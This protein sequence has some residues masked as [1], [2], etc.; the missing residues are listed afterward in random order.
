M[1]IH[2]SAGRLGG[3]RGYTRSRLAAQSPLAGIAQPAHAETCSRRWVFPP[4]AAPF[5]PDSREKHPAAPPRDDIRFRGCPRLGG[6]A[7]GTSPTPSS[8]SSPSSPWLRSGRHSEA[9]R[10]KGGCKALGVGY[11]TGQHGSDGAAQGRGWLLSLPSSPSRTTLFREIISKVVSVPGPRCV[12][13][14]ALPFTLGAGRAP[15]SPFARHYLSYLMEQHL[16][17][18]LQ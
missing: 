4:S 13:L 3:T 11:G 16:L 1:V 7:R 9:T 15:P 18:D 10:D 2:P 6:G 12:F 5:V 17:Q 8:P 14:P